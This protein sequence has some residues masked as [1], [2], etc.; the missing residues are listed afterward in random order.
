MMAQD[1]SYWRPASIAEATALF[2]SLRQA[3]QTPMY[4]AGGTEIL[5]RARNGELRPHAVIDIKGIE[6]LRSWSRDATGWHFGA[7]LSLDTLADH[8]P[9]PLLGH[10]AARIADHTSR[11]HITLGGNLASAL[12]YREAALP[13]W[14]VDAHITLADA[15]HTWT[16]PFDEAFTGTLSLAP[17]DLVVELSVPPSQTDLP[18]FTQKQTRLDFVD[19]PLVT[20]AAVRWP[21]GTVR[22][23]HSGLTS[24]P[25]RAAA[26]ELAAINQSGSAATRAA[27][28]VRRLAGPIV[29]D[30]HGSAD[31]RRFVYHYTLA[32]ALAALDREEA[33]PS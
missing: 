13:F 25:R 17:G 28:A 1:F 29:H 10:V 7:A 11:T 19:Y 5:T 16:V 23:A 20:L 4:Y 27:L 32:D 3:G 12:P 21:D 6:A 14:L 22:V 26:E 15:A 30:L 2:A 31:Y 18:F 8:S 9:W 24:T 33:S